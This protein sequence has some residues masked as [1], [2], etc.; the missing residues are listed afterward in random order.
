[1]MRLLSRL[2]PAT[3]TIAP[4]VP[5]DAAMFA[6]LHAACFRRGWTETEFEQMLVDHRVVGLRAL[7]GRDIVG[8]IVSRVVAGEAEILSVAVARSRRGRGLAGRMLDEHLRTLTSLGASAVL[9]E[10][11]ES[12]M[13]ARRLYARR[14]F[15]QV[16]ERRGYYPHPMGDA[17]TALVLRRELALEHV[18]LILDHSPHRPDEE[19]L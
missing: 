16:G 2:F 17:S 11:D 12:N 7:L 18:P 3:E 6:N 8:F 9:L 15:N 14:Q 1:M 19:V 13:P 4:A 10:V 5:G